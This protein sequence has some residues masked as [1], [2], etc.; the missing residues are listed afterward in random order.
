MK[1]YKSTKALRDDLKKAMRE[2]KRGMRPFY[3]DAAVLIRS[4][5]EK[6]FERGKGYDDVLWTKLKP[7]TIKRKSG[8]HA[9][10]R[11]KSKGGVSGLSSFRAKASPT[12]SK[13]LMDQGVLKGLEVSETSGKHAV[14][15]PWKSRREVVWI[16]DE[17]A[18]SIAGIH[19]KP[20][21]GKLPQ[22]KHFGIYPVANEKIIKLWNAML[23][24]FIGG[25][26]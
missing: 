17:R 15:R 21:G 25:I 4:E 22:R 3:R 6:G 20:P 8:A 14:L 2:F 26:S 16:G 24:D 5:R 19:E 1:K 12:P 9:G 18:G 13:P 23:K 10:Q 11:M 7:E